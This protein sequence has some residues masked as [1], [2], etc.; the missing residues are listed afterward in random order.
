MYSAAEESALNKNKHTHTR[1]GAR[2]HT[3]LGQVCCGGVRV[4]YEKYTR[5]RRR[6][7]ATATENEEEEDG[8]KRILRKEK[9]NLHSEFT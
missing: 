6:E 2:T 8:E 9:L 4:G 5:R 1:R 7:E 3:Q